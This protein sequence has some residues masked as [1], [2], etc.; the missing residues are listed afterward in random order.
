MSTDAFDGLDRVDA[1]G[2]VDEH[3]AVALKVFEGARRSGAKNAIDATTVET[4][5]PEA[6]LQVGNVVPAKI[7]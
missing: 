5:P 1:A 2:T 3:S 4:E 7:R 6:T